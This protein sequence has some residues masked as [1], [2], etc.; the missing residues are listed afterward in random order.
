MISLRLNK[1]KGLICPRS[2]LVNKSW[3]WNPWL[4]IPL[5]CLTHLCPDRHILIQEHTNNTEKWEEKWKSTY[6]KFLHVI[7]TNISPLEI[8]F[9]SSAHIINAKETHQGPGH[10]PWAFMLCLCCVVQAQPQSLGLSGSP[11][12]QPWLPKAVV[13]HGLRGSCVLCLSQ[14]W[15]NFE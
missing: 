8:I 1:I 12:G 14:A 7:L 9:C 5:S 3:S 4:M 10:H 6:W 13:R 11:Q 15:R 2:L